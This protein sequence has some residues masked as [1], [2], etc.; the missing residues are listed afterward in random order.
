MINHSVECCT[1]RYL[2]PIFNKPTILVWV[3][4]SERKTLRAF[5]LFV[6]LNAYGKRNALNRLVQAILASFKAR[7]LYIQPL[8]IQSFAYPDTKLS[9]QACFTPFFFGYITKTNTRRSNLFLV[10]SF[11]NLWTVAKSL[12]LK[13]CQLS[14]VNR[15]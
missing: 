4:L 3:A 11:N 1:D 2:R 8:F 5:L 15:Y 12:N 13:I 9:P 10:D 14:C 6:A 7:V